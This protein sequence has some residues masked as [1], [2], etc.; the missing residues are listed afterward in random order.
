MAAM[1]VMGTAASKA[2]ARREAD[3]VMD[4]FLVIVVVT[5]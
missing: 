1:D 3:E 2:I 5:Y 4:G